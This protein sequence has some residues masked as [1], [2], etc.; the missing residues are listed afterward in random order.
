MECKLDLNVAVERLHSYR[1]GEKNELVSF[2]LGCLHRVFH[3]AILQG[4]SRELLKLWQ[5]A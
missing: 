3:S 1:R 2:K 5:R 4:G